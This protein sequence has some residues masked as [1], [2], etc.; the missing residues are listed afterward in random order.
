MV[1]KR[2]YQFTRPQGHETRGKTARNRLRRVDNF[3]L[4]YTKSLLQKRFSKYRNVFVD[5]GY[6]EYPFTTIESAQRFHG[7]NKDL[8]IVGVEIDKERV[9][10]AS[11]FQKE[12]VDFRH[13]GFNLPL[14]EQSERAS[15][16]RAFNVLRQYEK[17]QVTKAYSAMLP[18]LTEGGILIE[19]TSD[20]LGR[21]WVA[22]LFR[23]HH[24]CLQ[25]E[26]VVFSTNFRCEFHPQ[27]FQTVL[28]KN[29]I[30]C[31]VAGEK[32]HDFFCGWKEAYRQSLYL[33]NWGERQ[34]FQK[35]IALLAESGYPVNSCKKYT[36]R[37][38]LI[39]YVND[40]KYV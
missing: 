19:G 35:S 32:M 31:V 1:D 21:I 18:Y 24:V 22:N 20:P 38:Y 37:G 3:V 6:G 40:E 14:C 9:L 28:P 2:H 7:V 8:Y 11:S 25:Q 36:S 10:K 23:K 12:H 13:G 26:A 30:E 27:N 16:I 29:Y 17:K 33:R 5:V 34:I 4:M 15:V 39:L